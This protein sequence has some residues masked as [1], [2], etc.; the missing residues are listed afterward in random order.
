MRNWKTSMVNVTKNIH[1]K[2]NNDHRLMPRRWWRL[3]KSQGKSLLDVVVEVENPRAQ[4][5]NKARMPVEP[6]RS[7]RGLQLVTRL[8]ERTLP[9]EVTIRKVMTISMVTFQVL[10]EP[11]GSRR[12]P[13]PVTRLKARA[14]PHEVTIRKVVTTSKVTFQVLIELQRSRR[15]LQLVT[16]R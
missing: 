7:R 5:P 1:R 13:Q 12:S 10:I 2:M 16:R 6:Q 8:K 11:Q 9:R 14:L 4:A 15:S 3:K